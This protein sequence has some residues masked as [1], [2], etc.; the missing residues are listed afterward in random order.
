MS[1]MPQ[2]IGVWC[3]QLG[4]EVHYVLYG[5]RTNIIKQIPE[6][7]D[8]VFISSFTFTAHLAY[9]ISNMLRSKGVVTVLGGPHA[10]CYPEDSCKYFDY[11]VG[12][13]NKDLLIEFLEDYNQNNSSGLYLSK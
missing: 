6:S 11:V 7:L 4:H 1:I 3:K 2:V 12:L 8:L 13:I 5:G 9:S 10:R